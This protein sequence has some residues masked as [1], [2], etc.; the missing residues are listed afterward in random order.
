MKVFTVAFLLS[1]IMLGLC[2]PTHENKKPENRI[3]SIVNALSSNVKG[4]DKCTICKTI[5]SFL[6]GIGSA[7][8]GIGDLVKYADKLCDLLHI[9]T[10]RICHSIVPEYANEVWDIF[11]DTIVEPNELCGWLL[12]KGCGNETAFF[13][14]WNIT[15]PEKTGDAKWSDQVH[16]DSV[17]K[18]LQLTDTHLDFDYMVGTKVEC[19]EP[20][21]CRKVDPMAGPGEIG[22]P[23]YGYPGFCDT[24]EL[25]IHSMLD[26][27]SKQLYDIDF[28]YWTGDLPAHNVWNQSKSDQVHSIKYATALFQK[29]FP[30]KIVYPSVGNHEG[31][32]V[33]NFPPPILTGDESGQW[34]RDALA[35]EWKTWLPEETIETI[36]KGAYY[37]VLMRKGF[38]IVSLNMNYG[39]SE[40][41]WLWI[42]S[43]DPAQQ[44]Q[45]FVE[46][47][48]QAEKN[49][50]KVHVIGH[51]PPDAT[52]KWFKYN[53]Y[54]IIDRFHGTVVGQFFGHTHHDEFKIF[55]DMKTYTT[56]IS[57]AY[58]APSVTTYHDLN[59]GYRIYEVDGGAA[60]STWLVT[61]FQTYFADLSHTMKTGDLHFQLEYSA[62][63]KYN[64]K[65]LL[66]AAWD[67]LLN[68]FTSDDDLFQYFY[69]AF[70]KQHAPSKVCSGQCKDSFICE[71]RWKPAVSGGTHEFCN[72]QSPQQQKAFFQWRKETYSNC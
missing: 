33:N 60:N 16:S 24:N 72:F 9:E 70:Y 58:V 10:S 69:K 50:E 21:C 17:I 28:I 39:N 57:I 41:W 5:V 11:F 66:P 6:H 44:L 64:M 1:L 15:L 29:Y 38:R 31:F 32:P 25:L 65:N 13:P 7:K 55:Y 56:P 45:W 3:K 51:I 23:K 22:A 46:V 40:N 48:T 14:S 52:L 67:D 59:P 27:I 8:E 2:F 61:D 36:K 30:G 54:R 26:N 12:G 18:I 4:I 35:K 42:N 34:L 37:T 20:L 19:G 47:L 71:A 68:R 63:K 53:Y 62:K 43:I 49:G